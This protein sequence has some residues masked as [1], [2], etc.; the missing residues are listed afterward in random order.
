MVGGQALK[1]AAARK[2]AVTL[3]TSD[4]EDLYFKEGEAAEQLLTALVGVRHAPM[5]FS[6][7]AAL[8]CCFCQTSL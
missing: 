8:L 2:A 1:V 3:D 7:T 5:P 4:T 6:A